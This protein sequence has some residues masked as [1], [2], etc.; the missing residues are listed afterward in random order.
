MSSTENF[1]DFYISD[2]ST[3]VSPIYTTEIS[4]TYLSMLTSEISSTYLSIYTSEI[5][6]TNSLIYSTEMTSSVLPI[7]TNDIS[8]TYLPIYSTEISATYLPI[9]NTEIS[10][11]YMHIY[12]TDISNTYLPIYTTEI[13]STVLPIYTTIFSHTTLP[14]YDPFVPIKY[15]MNITK[16]DMVN[17][18]TELI[19]SIEI[20]NYYEIE[21]SDFTLTIK[22]TNASYSPNSTHINFKE[23]E[24]ALRKFSN[25]PSSQLLTVFQMELDNNDDQSLVNQVEYQIYDENK[26]LLDLSIC[27][28]IDIQV[29]YA[30]KEDKL[31]E[32]ES[33]NHFKDIGVDIF[34]INDDFFKD[35]CHA[36][37]ESNNDITLKD[38][39]KDLYKNYTLCNDGCKYE[40]I[41]PENKTIICNC[42][43]KSNISLQAIN[44]TLQKL[45]EIQVDSNFALIKCYNLVFSF[46]NKTKNKG[47]WIF[48][49]LVAS[50][51]PL[52]IIFFNKGLKPIKEYIVKEMKKNGYIEDSTEEKII[53]KKEEK[54]IE[55]KDGQSKGNLI[56]KK[57]K[58]K[59]K[60]VKKRMSLKSPPKRASLK[61]VD[62][63]S[64]NDIKSS[65]REINNNINPI[66]IISQEKEINNDNVIS[67]N[68]NNNNNN[69]Q[70][71]IKKRHSLKGGRKSIKIIVNNG[72]NSLQ[73]QV[74]DKDN[75]G[76]EKEKDAKNIYNFNL[77]NINLNKIKEYTPQSSLH[78]LNNYTFEEAIQYDFRSI[79]AIFYIF[80]LSK[81]AICHAFLYRSPL[82]PFPLRLCLLIFIISC[83][84]ALN[85]LFYLDDK[86]SNKYK[87]AQNLFLFTFNSN[88]TIILLST[89]I[90]FVFMTLWTNL[91]S[92]TNELR[93][94]FRSEE[95][96][97]QKDKK[98][99]VSKER[100]KEIMETIE[101]IL[102]K[103][104]IKVIILLSIEIPIMLFFW[105]YVTAF[106]HVY[107]STQWS[108]ILDSF[109]SMLTRLIIIIFLSMLFAKLYR[110]SIESNAECIYKFVLFFYSFG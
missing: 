40:G 61:L 14:V 70:I 90:G 107:P 73:T 17:N 66:D 94:I 109:L 46:K 23:C 106:C 44:S 34:N 45:D 5:S 91:G 33:A 53:E 110:M 56:I 84:L 99:T 43:V 48:L 29:V 10:T 20:G 35:I 92:S 69:S 86:I 9:Y 12:T 103:Y 24:D 72:I 22:P 59:K 76:K 31:N 74:I 77:I 60:I 80:L 37:S 42:K 79:L 104:K 71:K 57:Q 15:Q 26:K 7:Y 54:I 47:F 2:F 41:D 68:K 65:G 32:I 28:D 97:I 3:N 83:D 93:N 8:T 108:W 98:Y 75:N 81:Q 100:K 51:I 96:K 21:G 25:I 88:I 36:Y 78:I 19:N 18:I 102:K 67:K 58:K 4:S 16:E 85:A 64:I 89:L 50:H 30:C 63:S 11:T 105:Y 62:N 39:I 101:R 38:R 87:Y 1:N 55:K 49:F 52:L 82:E 95:E 13:S 27:D 6:S